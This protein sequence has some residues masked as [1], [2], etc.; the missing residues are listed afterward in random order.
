MGEGAAV[1]QVDRHAA[2]KLKTQ[3][4]CQLQRI[5]R[6]WR[7]AA[8]EMRAV[9]EAVLAAASPSEVASV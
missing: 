7:R 5:L 9:G 1:G 8:L 2:V 4:R 6:R 3:A